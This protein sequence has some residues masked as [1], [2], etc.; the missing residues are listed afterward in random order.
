VNANFDPWWVV[1]SSQLSLAYSVENQTTMNDETVPTPTTIALPTTAAALASV[2]LTVP[3]QD[4]LPGPYE[5]QA[6]LENDTTDP[7]TV[8]GT[9]CLP[10]AVGAGTDSLNLGS[11]PAGSGGGGPTDTR[12]VPLSQELG[13]NGLRSEQEADW[14]TLLPIAT[15]VLRPRR[16]AARRPWMSP[17]HRSPRI[18][19][20][21]GRRRPCDLLV[22]GVRWGFDGHGPGDGRPVGQDVQALVA[23]Y[24]T[25]PAGCGVCAPVTMWE[26]WNE[27]NNTGWSSGAAYTT[28]VLI[29]FYN[30]V[31][32]VLPGNASTVLGARRWSRTWPGGTS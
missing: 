3:A 15:S 32:A 30:A 21:R 9:A 1:E 31:K 11:L 16:R 8:L 28:S 20:R 23:H 17:P 27:S 19:R 24:A 6:T 29:P 2:P 26:P 7:P 25:V 13:L 12:G 4:T 18:R 14:S 10:Y 22:P 5:V